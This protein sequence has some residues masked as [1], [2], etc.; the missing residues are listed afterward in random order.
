VH[1]RCGLATAFGKWHHHGSVTPDGLRW[2]IE[3]CLRAGH[4]ERL[5][6][7]GLKEERRL[8]IAGGLAIL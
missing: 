2:C 1:R 5:A 8:V 6:L 4:I 3:Q 7:P